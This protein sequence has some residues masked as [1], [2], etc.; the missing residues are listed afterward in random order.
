MI[1]ALYGIEYLS[2]KKILLGLFLLNSAVYAQEISPQVVNATGSTAT[3]GSITL[4]W[5][6]GEI[7][8]A[9]FLSNSSGSITS[10]QLQPQDGIIGVEEK[11]NAQVIL[12]PV[13][14]LHELNIS[15]AD[16]ITHVR[17]YDTTGRLVFLESPNQKQIV[18][19]VSAN[20][21][22]IYQVILYNSTGQIILNKSI[23]KVN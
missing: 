20:S 22:G 2:M 16:N 5:N 7:I 6:V 23:S 12:Y 17:I 9:T 15:S 10:G 3:I 13:P 14:A 19:D 8:S 4:E 18:I 1:F 11:V 21:A